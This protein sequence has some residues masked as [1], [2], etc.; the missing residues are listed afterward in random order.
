MKTVKILAIV[1]VLLVLAGTWAV[2]VKKANGPDG[3]AGSTAAVE[4]YVRAN[5]KTLAT[6]QPV[7][8]GS[9]YVVSVS[10]DEAAGMGQVVYED[11]H[12]QSEA[13]FNFAVDGDEV[14]ITNF[15][16]M[17]DEPVACT[18]DAK[19]CPD[20]SYVGRVGPNC[21]FATCPGN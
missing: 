12:I 2:G 10:V 4:N 5:I 16:P 1:V 20:G 7:L 13:N 15:V 18:M 9:W 8:G 17:V 3:S 11:G 14:K 19:E 21:D 6:D